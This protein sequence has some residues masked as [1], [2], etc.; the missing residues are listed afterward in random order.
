MKFKESHEKHILFWNTVF[1]K[2]Y[3]GELNNCLDFDEVKERIFKQLFGDLQILNNCFACK[4]C[5]Q[6]LF[7]KEGK[8]DY[9]NCYDCP[10]LG[11][12]DCSKYY[13]FRDSIEQGGTTEAMTLAQ[14]ICDTPWEES[15]LDD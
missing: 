15:N 6:R 2:I 4:I 3:K 1:D 12:Y 7:K 10:I 11:W 14:E 8:K 5:I 9:L 13:L